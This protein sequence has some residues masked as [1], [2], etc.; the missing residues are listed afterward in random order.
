MRERVRWLNHVIV[1][2]DKDQIVELHRVP[3]RMGRQRGGATRR[4][5]DAVS[6]PKAIKCT[7]FAFV[8][9]IPHRSP[10]ESRGLHFSVA[11]RSSLQLGQDALAPWRA[12]TAANR[13]RI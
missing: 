1:H 9:I 2:T 12:A 4:I 7:E 13:D 8:F 11:S 3:L 10:S 6:H 5:R